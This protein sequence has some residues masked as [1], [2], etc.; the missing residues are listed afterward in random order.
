[1]PQ[2]ELHLAT[3]YEPYAREMLT[4]FESENR[5][6]NKSGHQ[7]FLPAREDIPK[8]KYEKNFIQAGE[9]IFYLDY[10]KE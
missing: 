10:T 8:S 5:L 9:K 7:M 2:G 1:M 3:D 6:K 4:C